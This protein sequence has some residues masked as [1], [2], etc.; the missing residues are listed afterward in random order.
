M[1]RLLLAVGSY[2]SLS[3]LSAWLSAPPGI[4]PRNILYRGGFSSCSL[5]ESL[6]SAFIRWCEA[7]V[8]PPTPT[9]R[10]SIKTPLAIRRFLLNSI[11]TNNLP[12]IP[13]HEEMNENESFHKSACASSPSQCPASK[14]EK[15]LY[16]SVVLLTLHE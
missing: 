16:S 5:D 10:A 1:R 14:V 9:T 11:T 6:T 8:L 15:W 2:I 3:Q 12:H 4:V 13:Q 7:C